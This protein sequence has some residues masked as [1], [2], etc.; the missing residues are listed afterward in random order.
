VG[1]AVSVVVPTLGDAAVLTGAVRSVLRQTVD[2][3]VVL[4]TAARSEERTTRLVRSWND[5]RVRLTVAPAGASVASARNVGAERARSRVLAFLDDT[6]RW[7]GRKL[8]AQLEAMRATERS[9]SYGGALLFSEGRTP[10]ALLPAPPAEE[11][12]DRLPYANAVPGGGSNV[13]V[14]RDAFE[15]A[16]GFDP[17]VPHL[18]DWD[19]WIRLAQRDLP[20]VTDATVVACRHGGVADHTR[21]EEILSSARTLDDR[22][23]SLR[24]GQPLDWADL[25]RWLCHDAL[26]FGPRSVALRLGLGS[27]RRRHE[28]GVDLALRSLLPVRRRPPVGSLDEVSRWIDRRFPPRVVV[29]PDGSEAELVSLLAVGEDLG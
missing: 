5:P 16:E 13:I 9:W 25:H 28:G 24:G 10:E 1:P 12:V 23:R 21:L 17:S 2:V 27:L 29:W 4:V 22:Y 7:F 20:A 8:A 11:V 6:D 15:E 3:E 26:R 19:L 18:D 14:T